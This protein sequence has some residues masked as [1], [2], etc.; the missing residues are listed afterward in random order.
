MNRSIVGRLVAKDLYLQRWLIVAATLAGLV[1]LP[2]MQLGP[3]DGVTTGIN[4]GVILFMTTVIALGIFV[5]MLGVFRERQDR[6]LLFVLSLP[7]SPRQYAIAKTLSALLAFGLPWAVL[8][9]GTAGLVLLSD[10]AP[11]G[12]IPSFVAMMTFLFAN[13][14]VL[15][16]LVL[17]TTSERWAIAGILVTNTAV[18]AFL[19]LVLRLPGVA[20]HAKAAA[21]VWSP[22]VLA[23]IGIALA[24]AFAAIA[25]AILARSRRRD[26]VQETR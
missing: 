7:V 20:A 6:S 3:G 14:C 19:G 17:A 12:A 24:V 1:S 4:L 5:V 11:D 26:L 23:I 25:F 9:F 2:I 18:P 10:S 8:T 15:F 16:A 13:F 21:P 22:T